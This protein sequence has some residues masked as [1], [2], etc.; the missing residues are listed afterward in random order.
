MSIPAARSNKR[1]GLILFVLLI[2]LGLAVAGGMLLNESVRDAPA[3]ASSRNTSTRA[4]TLKGKTVIAARER[5]AIATKSAEGAA[6]A[7]ESPASGLTNGVTTLDRYGD[8]FPYE[9]K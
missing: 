9:Q 7:A 8:P 4:Q 5:P 1:W 3:T 2:D 6:A